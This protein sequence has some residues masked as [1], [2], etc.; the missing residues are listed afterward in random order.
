MARQRKVREGQ[1]VKYCG[2]PWMVCRGGQSD[3]KTKSYMYHLM[4]GSLHR[5]VRGNCIQEVLTA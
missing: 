5:M 3:P 1:K 4:R 2:K